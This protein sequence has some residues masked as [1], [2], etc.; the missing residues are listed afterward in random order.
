MRQLGLERDLVDRGAYERT[1]G[2]FRELRIALPTFAELADPTT[3]PQPVRAA[4]AGVDPDAPHP[5]NLFRVHWYN[6]ADR[7]SQVA[8]PE[9]LVLP[10][11]LTGVDA[12]IVAALGDRFPMIGAHKVLAA[13]G[14][15]APRVVTGQFDPTRHRAVWPSTGNYARGGVAISRIMGCRG[16]AVLPEGMSRERF[17]WLE[18]WVADPQDIIRTPGTESNVKEIYDRCK[19][20]AQ[21]PA[22]IIFNQFAE[23][24]NHLIHY[25][26]T[27]AA[28]ERIFEALRA[29]AP[30]LRL[31]AFV[32]ASGSAGTLGAGDYLKDRHGTAIVAVE[33]LE[34]PTML[35][36]GFGEHNIQGIGDKH[37]PLIHNVMNTDVVTAISD[38]STD[39]LDVLF[40]TA[41]GRDY[42]AVRRRVPPEV[43]DRLSALGLSSICNL[44]AAIK[45]AK[46]F[47]LGP[48]DVVIT[49]ATDG[50]AMYGTE[51]E[52]AL[53]RYFP[54]GFSEVNA[55]EVFAG[56]LLGTTTDHLLELS[57]RDRERIFNL[58]YFTWVEQ[59]GVS[60]EDFVA[61]R[62]QGFWRGLRDLLAVWDERIREFND[63][64]GVLR[65]L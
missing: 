50:A 16:V 31:R 38:R 17:A 40:N 39:Q 32:A 4:L 61:R 59:Q 25:C 41:V 53:H 57:I 21:D 52:K 63:R 33:A 54:T 55:G 49:V 20:L 9:H 8:I 48:E 30:G 36:N 23:F 19:A 62:P 58:G 35:Y 13:Y 60:V 26:C 65:T 18:R 3:I 22:N 43:I 46:H 5:L 2:R 10:K 7:R 29:R 47:R 14:C 15:L 6:S 51:R 12:P 56:H 28:L 27:G 44:V 37:I 34:C 11:A 64:T 45:V 42:L 1:V 24:G